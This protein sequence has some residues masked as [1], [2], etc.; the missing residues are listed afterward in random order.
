MPEV[1]TTSGTNAVPGRPVVQPGP[2]GQA[3]L[4]GRRRA[5]ILLMA[6]GDDMARQL[7]RDLPD[8]MIESIASEIASLDHVEP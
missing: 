7:L 2:N 6:L 4:T 5:A 3:N 1:M 8:P